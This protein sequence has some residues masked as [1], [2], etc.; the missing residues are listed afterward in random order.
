LLSYQAFIFYSSGTTG[1]PKGIRIPHRSILAHCVIGNDM[2]SMEKGERMPLPEENST[3][4]G[5]L[6][7]FHA[8][9][10]ITLFVMMSRGMTVVLNQKFRLTRFV[11][12]LMEKKVSCVYLVPS[13]LTALST[14]P[15]EI[16][17]PHLKLIYIGSAPLS[18]RDA[19]RFMERFPG[20]TLVQMYG[21]TEAGVL[22]FATLEGGDPTKVGVAMSGVQFKILNEN[23]DECDFNEPGAI[24]VKTAT[25]ANGYLHR[26]RFDE[27]FD[28]GDVGSVD[29]NGVLS[30]VERTKEMIKVRGWQVNP[31]ELESAIS[32]DVDGVEECAIVGVPFNGEI[33]PHA[34]IVG[35]PNTDE[36][37]QFVKDNFVSYKHL[38]AV[39]IVEELPK[40]ATGKVI[41]AALVQ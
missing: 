27:W 40:T 29:A 8:G 12:T 18:S 36:V 2:Y 6:P 5:V 21:L 10:L 38:R 7:L 41:K 31:Y 37:L 26:M 3:I 20:C 23:G 19:D 24:I 17:L 16:Q 25:M 11:Q 14:L 9:G 1:P 28:T 15:R 35:K 30:I 34:F 13:A 4:H 39:S 32:N 33:L 22:I